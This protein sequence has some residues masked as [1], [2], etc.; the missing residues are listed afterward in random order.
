M[1]DINSMSSGN[2]FALNRQTQYR[3][4]LGL[5]DKGRASVLKYNLHVKWKKIYAVGKISSI[6]IFLE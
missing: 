2:A 5:T 6:N 4:H 1:R 3:T